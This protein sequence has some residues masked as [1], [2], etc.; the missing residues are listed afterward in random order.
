MTR[1]YHRKYLDDGSLNPRW[2]PDRRKGSRHRT[3]KIK[4]YAVIDGEAVGGVYCVL[5]IYDGDR[6]YD[7]VSDGALTWSDII[8]LM[9]SSGV[10]EI[11]GYGLSYDINNWLMAAELDSNHL[12]ALSRNRRNTIVIVRDGW[13][14]RITHYY[15]KY[16]RIVRYRRGEDGRECDRVVLHC[17]DMY[18]YA[19]SSFVRWVDDWGLTIN[20]DERYMLV[21][22]KG[23]RATFAQDERDEIIEYNRLELRLLY[24]GVGKLRNLAD[25]CGYKPRGWYSPAS[26]AA[27]ALRRHVSRERVKYEIR[28][29][30]RVLVDAAY[31]GGR[32]E[33]GVVGMVG[34][35]IWQYDIRS[36]YPYALSSLPDLSSAEWVYGS[37]DGNPYAL[38]HVTWVSDGAIRY[39]PLPVRRAGGGVMY[40]ANGDGWYWGAEVLAAQRLAGVTITTSESYMPVGY[41]VAQPF[42]YLRELYETRKRYRA[43]GDQRQY[44]I[45]LIINS[46]YGK[47]AQR[48]GNGTW[49]NLIYAG[50]TTAITRAMILSAIAQS[51]SAVVMIATDGLLTT[52]QLDLPLGSDLGQWDVTCYDGVL[53][54]QSGVYWTITDGVVKSKTRGI[55]RGTDD[56][57]AALRAWRAGDTIRVPVRQYIGYRTALRRGLDQWGKWVDSYKHISFDPYPRRRE[58]ERH[59][60]YMITYA[61][62]HVVLS[63]YDLGNMVAEHDRPSILYDMMDGE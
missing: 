62:D 16:L 55:R 43:A 52:R 50:L 48:V 59:N 7:L 63:H 4:P 57:D 5:Q 60:D 49:R 33:A 6:Y 38:V 37:W 30:V 10:S 8:G 34:G 32:F 1:V 27:A 11:W 29:D 20:T 21:K 2:R 28:D 31:Y 47:L 39:G 56:Y 36:A 54:A 17:Y 14:Y 24:E 58:G 22:M 9:L 42:A 13:C 23:G 26:I 12:T 3:R 61:Q 45:K 51:P 35:P 40:P 25:E 41:D 53:I 19:G 46:T 44:V 18:P 15:G